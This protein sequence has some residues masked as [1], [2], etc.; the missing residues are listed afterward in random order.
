MTRPLR[1]GFDAGVLGNPSCG[2]QQ[3]ALNML[4]ALVSADADVEYRLTYVGLKEDLGRFSSLSSPRVRIHSMAVGEW[5]NRCKLPLV[6]LN[7]ALG[8][9]MAGPVDLYFTPNYHLPPLTLARRRLAMV[10]DLSVLAHPE[11]YGGAG[12]WFLRRLRLA[13]RQA[14]AVITLSQ[15]S[16]QE[17]HTR[18]GVPME[19]IHVNPCAAH[20]RFLHAAPRG[21]EIRARLGLRFPYLLSVGTLQPR[22]NFVRLIDAF[23]RL[24]GDLRLVIVGR[25]G[26][27]FTEI[28]ERAAKVEGVHIL[29]DVEDEDLPAV[30]QGARAFCLPSLYEGFGIPLLEAM[31][32]GVPVAASRVTSLPEVAGGAAL[33]FDPQEVEDMAAALDS[34]TSDES[35]R[36]RLTA[37]G[38]ERARQFSWEGSAAELLAVFRSLVDRRSA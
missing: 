32:S 20:H 3:Y 35:V 28:L 17:L 24:A 29:E 21:E 25:R 14:D 22:K 6:Y 33:L 7:Y 34:L 37:A 30:Y 36:A 2:I 9:L 31:A 23:S 18:L 10:P 11:F 8:G 19:K 4:S 15:F 27:D 38:R 12:R 1:I 13:L 26:W 16:R 5:F